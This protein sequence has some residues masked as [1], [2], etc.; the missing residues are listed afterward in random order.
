[1]T[2]FPHVN[3]LSPFLHSRCRACRRAQ[4]RAWAKTEQGKAVKRRGILRREF[5]L[6]GEAYDSMLDAQAG[7]CAI[8]RQPET[9]VH[10]DGGALRLCVDH[11]H[12]TGAVRGLL[13]SGCNVGLG[14]F[15]DDIERLRAAAAYLASFL[16]A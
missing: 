5:R 9:K 15:N 1:M 6:T 13:C 2:P 4:C 7:V 3:P 16:G 8:C 11:D 14:S 12:A 10:R